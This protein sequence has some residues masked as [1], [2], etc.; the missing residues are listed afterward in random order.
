MI[1]DHDCADIFCRGSI[2]YVWMCQFNKPIKFYFA[3]KASVFE[4]AWMK[5][6]TRQQIYF[7][8]GKIISEVL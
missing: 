3:S 6:Q 8:N 2:I 7:N 4:H 1:I 5:V